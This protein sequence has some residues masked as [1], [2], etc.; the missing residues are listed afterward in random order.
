MTCRILYMVIL[1]YVLSSLNKCTCVFT[2]IMVAYV[3][4]YVNCRT[5]LKTAMYVAFT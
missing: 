1:K 3:C 2:K 5:L 4:I